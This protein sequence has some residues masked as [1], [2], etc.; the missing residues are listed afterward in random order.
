MRYIKMAFII[1]DIIIPLIIHAGL[2]FLR[3]GVK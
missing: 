1:S 2:D 3:E